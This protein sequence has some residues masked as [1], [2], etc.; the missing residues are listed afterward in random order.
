MLYIRADMN[1]QIATGHIMRCLSI[2]DAFRTI[3]ESVIFM[4]ADE[5]AVDLLKQRGY[6]AVVLHTEWNHMEEELPVLKQVIDQYSMDQLLIDSYQVT[7]T[8]LAAL[9]GWVKTTYIDDLNMFE[10][11]VDA[12]ICYANYWKK[13]GYQIN[14]KEKKYYL[15][16]QYVPL[17]QAFWNC[18]KKI[19]SE[20]AD[21]LL[22]LTGGSDPYNISEQIL[23]S[24]D[25][26]K[27]QNIDVICGVYNTNYEQL[28]IKY[29]N[30]A[31]VKFHRAVN[32]I[33]KYM[34]AADIVISAGGTTLY[35]LCACGTPAISYAFADNQLDNVRQ[36]KEDGLIDYAGDARQDDIAG[37]I[38][39]YLN[40]YRTNSRL[41]KDRSE[42][43]QKM[44]DGK[45]AMRLAEV[46]MQF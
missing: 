41:R 36:F 26:G 1:K 23:S 11:P 6:D 28:L 34:Q 27:F 46:L 5:Q 24:I 10:Y 40:Q 15:G 22:I 7:E 44:V 16:T 42:R 31:N 21:K 2:A 29:A 17:R 12:I 18:E 13:F 45:G 25:P 37:N 39:Q 43:M 38:N 19:I 4:L 32:D 35:E 33:E 20:T 30:L 14:K 9:S 3:G 8:Y